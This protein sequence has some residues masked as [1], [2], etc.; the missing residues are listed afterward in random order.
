MREFKVL[1]QI[2][3]EDVERLNKTEVTECST[4]PTVITKA[5]VVAIGSHNVEMK[6]DNPNVVESY[7]T[8]SVLANTNVVAT[9]YPEGVRLFYIQNNTLRNV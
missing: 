1:L 2:R 9:F 5:H 6:S 8:D 4:E 3:S 7:T